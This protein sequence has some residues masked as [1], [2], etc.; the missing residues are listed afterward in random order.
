VTWKKYPYAQVQFGCSNSP[1]FIWQSAI[2]L[3]G[4]SWSIFSGETDVDKKTAG[5]GLVGMP[6]SR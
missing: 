1:D 3:N 6:T 5:N 2:Y 4:V